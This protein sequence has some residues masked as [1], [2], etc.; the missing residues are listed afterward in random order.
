MA[1]CNIIPVKINFSIPL[2]FSLIFINSTFQVNKVATIE[3]ETKCYMHHGSKVISTAERTCT[4]STRPVHGQYKAKYVVRHP[5]A[6]ISSSSA[7]PSTC[8]VLGTIDIL[9]FTNL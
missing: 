7:Q 5:R 6:E 4:A 8:N 1:K 9:Y 3:S 2:S